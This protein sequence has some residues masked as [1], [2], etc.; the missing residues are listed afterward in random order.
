MKKLLTVLFFV[1]SVLPSL[2]QINAKLMR[3]MD[4]SDSQIAFVYGGDIWLVAKEG[5]MATQLTNS[6]GE[7]SWPRFSPDG[8]SIAFSA[9]YNGNLDVYTMPVTGGV[10]TRVTYKSF[11]DRMIDW[12]PDGKRLLI[13]STGELGGRRLLNQFFL[14]GKE[15]GFPEKLPLPYGELAS[16]SPDGKQLAY[17]TKITENYPFKRIRSGNNSDILIYD[18]ASNKVEN[19]T[20]RIAIDGKPAWSGNTVYFLS[21]ENPDMRLNVW[22][23]DTK[24]KAMSQLTNFKDFDVSF[25]SASEKDLVFEM[26]GDLYLMDLASRNY[27]KIDVRVISDLSVEIPQLKDVSKSVAN[28]TVSPDGKRVVLQARGE[29]FNVPAKEGFTM[30]MTQSSG[31]LDHS[32]AWSPDGKTVAYWSDQSGEYE[33]YLQASQGS[34][35]PKKLTNRKSGFGYTLHWSPDSKK[36]A[37]LDEKYDISI[38]DVASG[39]IKKAGNTYWIVGHGGA[40]S[41]PINWSPDSKYLAFTIGQE[42]ANQAIH[43]Y[44]T[45]SEK[46]TK[47]TSG[48]YEDL[49]P[50]FSK[51][52]KYLFFQTNRNMESIYS[53][54]GDGTWVYSNTTQLGAISLTKATASILPPKNDTISIA[55]DKKPEEKKA[56]GVQVNIDFDGLESRIVLLPAKPGN[57]GKMAAIEDKLIY[58]RYPRTGSGETGGTLVFYD[59]KEREEKTI[60]D[61]VNNYTVTADGKSILVSSNGQYAVIAANAG[62]KMEKTVPTNGLVMNW[63]AR[64]EWNQIFNDTWRRYRDFFYDPNMQ[65]VDWED[66]RKRYGA[67][68][69]DARTR[70][71]ITNIQSNMQAELAAG[72]TYTNGGDTESV[73]PILT[74]FLGIKWAKEGDRYK[75]GR[76]VKPASWNTEVRSPF[77]RPGVEVKEG[78]YIIAVNGIKLDPN[79]DPYAAFEGLSGKTVSLTIGQKSGN[80]EVSKDIVITCLTPAE[81]SNLIYLEW[82]ENNRKMVEKLSDGQL[83]YIYMSNTAGDGQRELITMYYGQLDKKG[84]I[85]DERFNGGGQLADRFM[86]L[87]LRPVVYNLHWR[88][89]RDHTNPIKANTGPMGMLINGWAGSGGDGLPWAFKVLKAGP[90]VG[91]NTLGILV[92]PATGHQLIDGGGITVPDARLYDN[93]GHWFWEGEGVSPDIVVWDDPNVIM[94][95]R[96]PQMERVVQEVVKLIPSKPSKMTPAPAY[97]DRTAKGMK[98]K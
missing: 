85:I 6:P 96:D 22:A 52:G 92:G 36:I 43:I 1:G 47:A 50:V 51:D 20:N 10:P 67:L 31:A 79:K 41:F 74:G 30:N 49:S 82:I 8:K 63:V 71:D 53:D 87:L 7:E 3:Y 33:I 78:D 60:L 39:Q 46:L 57:F 59:I 4:V 14:V 56:N 91:E 80:S 23:Y 58:M 88:N 69:K 5:G 19:I 75:I 90:V 13:G 54:L 26:G 44:D 81:E 94:Q 34:Q 86:E 11:P 98:K 15:G 27:K 9:S 70:W 89:G 45:A 18:V 55:S 73:T 62:Q 24:T 95:G 21:D 16:F 28:M 17:I 25:L 12:H 40:P 42:N 48:F 64:E 38:V 97:E 2:G 93:A 37:F 61:K 83:G 76:I 72:H 29:L 65:G 32:P 66:M 77:D 68:I 84:F 35:E